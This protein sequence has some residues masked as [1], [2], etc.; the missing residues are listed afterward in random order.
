MIVK[1]AEPEGYVV[2]AVYEFGEYRLDPGRRLLTR[3]DGTP[4]PATSRVFDTLLHLVTNAGRLVDKRELMRAVWG[5]TIVEENNLTQAISS[6]RQLLGERPNE[7]RFIV[8]VP[9][10]GYRF[11]AEV[12]EAAS[13]EVNG[14]E[15]PAKEPARPSERGKAMRHSGRR[16]P[17]AAGVALLAIIAAIALYTCRQGGFDSGPDIESVAILP[18]RPLVAGTRDAALEL[19]MADTLITR[20]SKSPGIVVRPLSSVRKYADLDQDPVAAGREL[21]VEA[22]LDGSIHREGEA[23]RVTARLVRV[24]DGAALWA[25]QIDQSWTDVFNVQDL[26]A[27]QVVDALALRL[28]REE[29]AQLDHRETESGD[30]Y[31][32]YV[33]GRYHFLKLVPH[34][35]D[36]GIKYFRQAIAVD[37]GYAAAYAGL[38]EAY[39]ALAITS[40]RRPAEVLPV[41]KA[42]ALKAIELDPNHE[43]AFASLC[44]IQIW[45]DWDWQGAEHSCRQ[46]LALDPNSADGHRAYAILLSDL[47]RH[48]QALAMAR[49]AVELDPLSLITRAIEGHVLLYAGKGGEA[50][51]RLRAALELEPRFWIARLFA[52]KAYLDRGEFGKALEEFEKARDFSSGNSETLSMI[53]YTLARRN[54]PE[55]A[56]RI[57]AELR[58][59]EPGSYLPPFNVAM[60]YNGLGDRE[61][62]FEWLEKA[63][64]ERD[65]RLTFLKVEQKWDPIRSDERFVALARRV[66]L[67]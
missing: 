46:S 22:V 35:I 25:D 60:I 37:P 64:A 11:I 17:A 40:D 67:E 9:A 24:R 49:R 31:R 39:R 10:R 12:T 36:K 28:T 3:R 23:L 33:L 6:L 34:E 20:L 51:D 38:A 4:V 65:V 44:F 57:L 8:T 15:L 48:E 27:K 14:K 19:G 56:K 63:Y 47:G 18:F 61:R 29:R 26:I 5:E 50:L 16:W 62:A 59:R 54:D 32:F 2:Q 66:G 42:A 58:A 43:P 13:E 53:G 41:G 7:H 30:A 21:G 45:W 52:G 1:N 55:G